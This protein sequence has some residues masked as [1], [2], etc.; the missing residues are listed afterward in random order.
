[1]PLTVDFYYDFVS[2]YSYLAVMRLDR[3]LDRR[4]PVNW[5]PILL[6]QLI[7]LSGNVSP[8]TIRTKAL[9]LLRDLKRWARYLEV[10][11]VMQRPAFFDARPA[12][13]AAQAREGADRERLSRAVFEAL[14]GAG[15]APRGNWLE[16]ILAARGLPADWAHPRH[17]EQLMAA[18][19]A[20]TRAAFRSGAFGAPSF[21][22]RGAGRPELFWGVDRMDFLARATERALGVA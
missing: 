15:R 19:E 17:P 3:V 12:L 13:R 7:K 10:P 4:V 16:E 14:W 11:F 2:P 18:L 5:I 20:N 8:A 9:Y 21:V 6:P 1:M 22:L